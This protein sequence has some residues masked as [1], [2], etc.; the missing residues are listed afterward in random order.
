[1]PPVSQQIM[2]LGDATQVTPV[3]SAFAGAQMV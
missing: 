1:M 2:A 3:S